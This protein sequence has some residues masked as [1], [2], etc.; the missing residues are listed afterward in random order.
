ML[1]VTLPIGLRMR[2]IFGCVRCQHPGAQS[3]AADTA[4]VCRKSYSAQSMVLLK[5][6]CTGSL[7][8]LAVPAAI[9]IVVISLAAV[10]IGVV[11]T[12][13][14]CRAGLDWLP[15]TRRLRGWLQRWLI[16][17]RIRIRRAW[18]WR[19]R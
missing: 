17:W 19:R 3:G 15:R 6:S 9:A 18:H 12:S 8:A 1:T 5:P 11:V 2:R 14:R 13:S 7:F 16:D 4:Q 10:A